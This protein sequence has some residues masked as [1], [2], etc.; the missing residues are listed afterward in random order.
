MIDRLGEILIPLTQ[1][2]AVH[3]VCFSH[4]DKY[5]HRAPDF[6][7][8]KAHVRTTETLHFPDVTELFKTWKCYLIYFGFVTEVD[9]IHLAINLELFLFQN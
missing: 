3:V 6:C 4:S 1:T 9:R 7:L 5:R 8:L 2:S